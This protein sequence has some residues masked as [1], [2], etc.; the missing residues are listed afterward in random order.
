M[1]G[2]Q[3]KEYRLRNK[4]TQ[5]ELGK[6]IGVGYRTIQNYE[7]GENIPESKIKQFETLFKEEIVKKSETFTKKGI[8]TSD[9]HFLSIEE[10][11][12][13][14]VKNFKELKKD[15]FFKNQ[16]TIECLKIMEEAKDINGNIDIKN[17]LQ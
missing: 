1:K 10:I 12:F 11:A 5:P 7:A 3:I 13:Y 4:L 14:C 15:A 2:I 16:L 8:D 9:I 17:L 6:K